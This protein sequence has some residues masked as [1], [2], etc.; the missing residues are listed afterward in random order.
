MNW[1]RRV[2][3]PLAALLL[4]GLGAARERAPAG[5]EAAQVALGRRLFYDADLSLD[6]SMACATC[7]VQRHGFADSTRTRAGVTGEPGRRNVPGL[8]NVGRRASLTWG[9]ATLRTLEAQALVPLQGEHPVEMGM[10]GQ[11]GELARRLGAN[12]CYVR[13]FRAG[14]PEVDGRIDMATV[15]RALGTFQRSLLSADAPVDCARGNDTAGTRLFRR[16]CATC[17]SGP[18]MT[19]DRFHRVDGIHAAD[20]GLGEISGRARD[21]GRFR[22][23]SLRNVAV[24]APYFHD[25]ASPTLADAIRRHRG[26]RLDEEEVT[27]LVDHLGG[28]T[29]PTFLADP[30]FAYPDGP[31]EAG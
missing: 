11:D 20:R 3:L 25:G 17:H 8:A 30:R 9:D 24:S 5:A 19:D 26:L 22:T 4:A 14:F 2:A 1:G 18:D 13:L 7:H 23:P 27:A 31:C 28:F 15:T 21:D 29:D 6:G 10:K 16:H 12:G